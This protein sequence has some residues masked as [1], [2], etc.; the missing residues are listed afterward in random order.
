MAVNTEQTAVVI[1]SVANEVQIFHVKS[2][3]SHSNNSNRAD[4]VNAEE[5]YKQ[6]ETLVLQGALE[7]DTTHR[8]SC[9]AFSSNSMFLAACSTG[10][11]PIHR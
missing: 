2:A 11:A 4:M 1:G 6:T 10:L 5:S 9:V 3:E 8:V 7:H